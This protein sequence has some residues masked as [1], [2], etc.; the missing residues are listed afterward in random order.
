MGVTDSSAGSQVHYYG[1]IPETRALL[2]M[3]V[4]L[5]AGTI[6]G[7]VAGG[8]AGCLDDWVRQLYFKA[9]LP[10]VCGTTIGLCMARLSCWLRV[11]DR[12]LAT[13]ASFYAGLVGV[14]ASW[15]G[16]FFALSNHQAIVLS[17]FS[18]LTI[19]AQLS[20]R[21]VYSF[22]SLSP[23]GFILWLMWFVQAVVLIG[24]AALTAR[25]SLRDIVYCLICGIDMRPGKYYV[26]LAWTDATSRLVDCLRAGDLR[27]LLDDELEGA[28][29]DAPQT[30]QIV[31]W[32]CPK[33]HFACM[34]A[35]F[36]EE[37]R[38]AQGKASRA[39]LTIDKL[40]VEPEALPIFD[41]LVVED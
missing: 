36:R 2:G 32:S 21:G 40:I 33:K 38:T 16:W 6:V 9:G 18:L 24:L 5:A 39:T 8:L 17:P 3:M 20:E 4:M 37:M 35:R 1:D 23:N 22:Q 15:V 34:S 25:A 31:L 14:Y 41:E 13:V 30:L 19:G 11:H 12:T 29:D 10:F 28:E 27:A 26:P 7:L